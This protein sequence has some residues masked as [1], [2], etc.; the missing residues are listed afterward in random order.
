VRTSALY[1]RLKAQGAVFE[2]LAG[3]ERPYWFARDGV[4]QAHH[5]GFR[6]TPAHAAIAAEVRAVRARA[7]VL[8]LSGFAKL[9]VS[10]AHAAA[11]LDR[12]TTNRLPARDGGIALTY[13]L[14]DAGTIE[15]ELTVTRLA[16][17][18][19]FLLFAALDELRVR[20]WIAERRRPARTWRS[21]TCRTAPARSS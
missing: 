14:N 11:L 17:D 16:A 7:G 9:E 19:F 1:Q 10:G 21:R 15:A 2:Q 13:M 18:R 6:R 5:E 3:W 8:D 20:D 4:P 12:L